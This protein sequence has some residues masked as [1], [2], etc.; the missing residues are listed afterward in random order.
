MPLAAYFRNVGAVL[1]ALLLIAEFYLPTPRDFQ[2]VAAY[3][4]VIRIYS[5]RKELE[6]V[7]FNT[8]QVA[9]A[10]VTLAPWDRNPPA[11]PA[12]HEIPTNDVETSRVSNALALHSHRAASVDRRRQPTRKYAARGPRRHVQSQIVLTAR[13]R[14]YGWFGFSDW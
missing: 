1:L 6:P 12:A 7:I 2:K 11:P 10:A 5:E 3:R 9:F 14:Q 13:P 4:P 8:T